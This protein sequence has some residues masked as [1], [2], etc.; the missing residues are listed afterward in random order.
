MR[1]WDVFSE[2]ML[3]TITFRAYG[4]PEPS[5]LLHMVEQV[6]M[7]T[8]ERTIKCK[9][10]GLNF[11][12]HNGKDLV[13]RLSLPKY[14]YGNNIQ[15]LK[16]GDLCEV[17]DDLALRFRFDTRKTLITGMDISG[18]IALQHPIRCYVN[19]VESQELILRAKTQISPNESITF[20]NGERS[21][22]FYDKGLEAGVL[23]RLLR[24]E[25]SLK[26]RRSVMNFIGQ[27]SLLQLQNKKIYAKLVDQWYR[28]YRAVIMSS[29][30][31][32]PPIR[33]HR[34]LKS[35]S[36]LALIERDG[37]PWLIG[38]VDRSATGST[39]T[40][41]KKYLFA[42]AEKNRIQNPNALIDELEQA[43]MAECELRLAELEDHSRW[44]LAS[45]N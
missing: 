13:I 9:D 22:M 5:D 20:Y 38:N 8:G 2:I 39:R 30:S 42:V 41:L 3:D 14:A 21:L 23:D 29:D 6:N 24:I 4:A 36:V 15:T 16:Y 25:Y 18:T 44:S 31:V 33:N 40:E 32:C 27:I 12:S 17:V 34:D 45:H 11:I 19:L 10:K 28:A 1:H 7:H 35:A 26:K 37:M 43:V